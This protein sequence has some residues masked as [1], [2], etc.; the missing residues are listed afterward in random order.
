MTTYNLSAFAGAGAQFFD[1]NGVPLVGGKLYTYAAGTT[2][3]LATYTTSAG[4]VANSNPII[5]N[6][7]GRTPNEIWLITGSLYKFIL[8]TSTDVL[9]GTYDGVPSINDP[10]GIYSQ[11]GSVAGTNSI[12][13]VATP[14][15]TSYVS[16]AT[17][18]FIA[19]NTNTGAATISIDG[20]A[21]KSITKN[22]SVALTAGDIQIGK[23]MLIEYDGTVFQLMNNI[24]YG[25]S[26]ADA[27]I[28]SLS[29]P[30]TVANGGTGAATFT[31]NAV[32][33]GNNTAAFQTVA[34]GTAGNVLTSDGTTWTSAASIAAPAAVGQ[35]PF[36]TDGTT[37]TAT[38]KIAQGTAVAS[39]SGTSI[40]FT[41]IPSWVKRVTVMFNGVSLNGTSNFLVQM[42]AGSIET[43]GY[44]STAQS[45][46]AGVGG[47]NV[48]STDGIIIPSG[49][50]AAIISGHMILTLLGSNIWISSH[51]GKLTTV[52]N[53]FGAGDKTLSGTLDRVRITTVN[54][55]DTFDGGSVNILYE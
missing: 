33:L 21:A 29:S 27:T 12:T 54:G 20:L 50:A 55:T 40:D 38:Q 49:A 3:P 7:A 48:S 53:C 10:F 28:V 25:S 6:A 31:A 2:T 36:S 13:A 24:V 16:G 47:T 45:I 15:I 22:G 37:Y 5:L 4:T 18:S 34:P 43:T 51:V 8:R 1:D 44:V 32:L 26:L 9:I 30:L 42:G 17:Y 14:T 46:T 52:A 35:I 19:A 39:T 11:L 41:G 23:M